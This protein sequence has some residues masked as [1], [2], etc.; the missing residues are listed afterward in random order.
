MLLLFT[1]CMA[2]SRVGL[3]ELVEVCCINVLVKSPIMK[4]I[5]G[6]KCRQ[7]KGLSNTH[8]WERQMVR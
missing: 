1:G 6:C 7:S 4:W 3:A 5:D 8:K 2:F